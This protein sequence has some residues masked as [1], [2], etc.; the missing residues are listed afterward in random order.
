MADVA[1]YVC[2]SE[3][4]AEVAE[5]RLFMIHAQAMQDRSL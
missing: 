1:G 5:R 2:Q 4:P 3:V